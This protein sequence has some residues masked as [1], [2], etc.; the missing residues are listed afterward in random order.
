MISNSTQ[1]IKSLSN[2]VNDVR[3]SVCTSHYQIPIPNG[4]MVWESSKSLVPND[5][6]FRLIKLLNLIFLN[7]AY[8]LD[9]SNFN[10]SCLPGNPSHG[11]DLKNLPLDTVR[12]YYLKHFASLHLNLNA[13]YQTMFLDSASRLCK[14]N[15][16][17]DNNL[18]DIL[19]CML[20]ILLFQ[21]I[22]QNEWMLPKKVARFVSILLCC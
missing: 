13:I 3:S 22:V 20:I 1:I 15:I 10:F 18:N 16:S 14:V 21:I 9:T 8:F 12:N 7:K 17:K 4:A 6:V 2:P 11:F 19:A 5:T